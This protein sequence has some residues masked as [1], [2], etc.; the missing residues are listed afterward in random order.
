MYLKLYLICKISPYFMLEIKSWILYFRAYVANT[1]RTQFFFVL[2]IDNLANVR[3][4]KLTL[5]LEN[6]QLFNHIWF[7]FSSNEN[8][9]FKIGHIYS[10]A[11]I[12]SF[13]FLTF[14]PPAH[15]NVV[16]IHFH[17]FL[18]FILFFGSEKEKWRRKRQYLLLL[19][20]NDSWYLKLILAWKKYYCVYTVQCY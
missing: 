15:F 13:F 6:P 8:F 19:S 20:E 4:L 5:Y 10:H 14:F 3:F 17:T 9:S 16:L 12:Q 7:H 18:I 1:L 2:K 11:N